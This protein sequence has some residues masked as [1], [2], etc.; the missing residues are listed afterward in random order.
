MSGSSSS[1]RKRFF[2][3]PVIVPENDGSSVVASSPFCREFLSAASALPFF[4]LKNFSVDCL[5]LPVDML[6]SLYFWMGEGLLM[7]KSC[8][9]FQTILL[10]MLEIFVLPFFPP[11]QTGTRSHSSVFGKVSSS[12]WC[13]TRV[14]QGLSN[15]SSLT[16]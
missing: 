1:V 15:G 3:F 10:E 11:E 14:A 4:L 13:G 5:A 12:V 16:S 6:N 2:W 7:K 8:S 9:F